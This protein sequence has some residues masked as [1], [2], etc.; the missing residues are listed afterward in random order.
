MS[1]H[2]VITS[3]RH[4]HTSRGKALAGH[5]SHLETYELVKIR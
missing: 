3:S 2:V 1:V 4:V 5:G